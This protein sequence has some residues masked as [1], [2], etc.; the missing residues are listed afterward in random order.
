MAAWMY[1][2]EAVVRNEKRCMLGA[3]C[4]SRAA[5]ATAEPRSPLPMATKLRFPWAA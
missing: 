1:E 3:R 5:A 4:R 2:W